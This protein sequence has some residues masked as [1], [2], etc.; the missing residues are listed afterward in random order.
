M[1]RFAAARNTVRLERPDGN[2]G[3]SP[4]LRR[5]AVHPDASGRDVRSLHRS[6]RQLFAREDGEKP[7]P[8]RD[9][10]ADA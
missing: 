7:S 3:E 9:C 2:R 1:E 5:L 4:T 6:T 10:K 8:P